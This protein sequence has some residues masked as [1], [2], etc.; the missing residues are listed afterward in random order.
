MSRPDPQDYLAICETKARYCRYLD[1]KDWAGYGDVF[2]PD[3]V[4]DT[5]AS[6]G[7]Q[8]EGRE[9]IVALVRS[10]VGEAI[11]VHQVHSPEIALRDADTAEVIWAMQD[12]IVWDEA[13][14]L[15]TGY[16]GLTGYGHYRETCVRC[17]DGIWRISASELIRSH[18]DFKPTGP[19]DPA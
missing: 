19:S 9:A 5:R 4:L 13:K 18:M 11:T 17:E 8:V 3:A 15:A 14:A 10:A 16:R 12:R 1:R 2:T 7:P 6:N